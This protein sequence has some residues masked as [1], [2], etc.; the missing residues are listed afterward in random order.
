MAKD[1]NVAIVTGNLVRDPELRSTSSGTAVAN[2]TVASNRGNDK[3]GN[4]RGADFIGVTA[5]GRTAENV[6]EYLRKGSKVLIE[7][8]IRSS[9]YELNGEKRYKT[10]INALNVRFLGKPK[11]QDDYPTEHMQA[12]ANGYAPEPD[13]ELDIPF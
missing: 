8:Q 11:N 2:F 5:W 10:E 6:C 3:N 12:K 4:D 7:G 13:E 1:T 9:S